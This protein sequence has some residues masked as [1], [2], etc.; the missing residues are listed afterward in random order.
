MTEFPSEPH[1]QG[2][3][4]AV[5]RGGFAALNGQ[6]LLWFHAYRYGWRRVRLGDFA[7][8]YPVDPKG[9]HFDGVLVGQAAQ[10]Y[11]WK[12]QPATRPAPTPEDIA[13]VEARCREFRA[14]LAGMDAKNRAAFAPAPMSAA[15]L[16]A[17]KAGLGLGATEETSAIR[18]SE[19]VAA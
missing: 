7:Q 17:L 12:P 14:N 16:E 18:E 3:L 5:E 10:F 6:E 11:G 2:L 15:D 9:Q 8:S 1:R 19:D 13:H 4:G